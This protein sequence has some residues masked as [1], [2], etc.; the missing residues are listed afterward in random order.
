MEPHRP[1]NCE[2]NTHTHTSW[3]NTGIKLTARP[4]MMPLAM[5]PVR[6][7]EMGAVGAPAPSISPAAAPSGR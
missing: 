5:E 1:K 6:A 7:R 2:E 3:S 4:P